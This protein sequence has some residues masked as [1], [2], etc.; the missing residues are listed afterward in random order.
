MPRALAFY[1][2]LGLAVPPG[3]EERVHVEVPMGTLTFFLNTR[4]SNARWDPARTDPAGGYR[5]I[6]E[7]NLGTDAAVDRMYA[8][9][10]DAGYQSHA[11]PY[12]VSAEMRFAMVDDPDA[13]TIL[14]SGEKS[15]RTDRT[16]VATT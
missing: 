12:D 14:L 15:D 13:N 10:I 11:A 16:N 1:Q 6:L 8:D 5:V 7:F 2:R 3:S 4:S 9:L